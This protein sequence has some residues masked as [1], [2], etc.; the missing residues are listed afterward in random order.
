MHLISLQFYV[1]C[2]IFLCYVQAH[3]DA[4]IFQAKSI[5]HYDQLCTI[6]GN[7]QEILSFSDNDTEIEVNFAVDKGDPDLAIVSEIQTD[8]N[9]TKCRRWT[10]HM[11]HW[12][13]KIL[14][15]Q[16]RKGRKIN[17]VWLTE[18]YDTAVSAINSKFGLHLT[19]S[20]I[21]H[22]LK[23]WKKQYELLKDILS[24]TGFKWDETKKMIVA[25]DST[26]NDYIRVCC[27]L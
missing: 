17:N 3:P 22:R 21:K 27:L 4:R 12:L 24:H 23:T 26:W 5:E 2:L 14:V 25:N 9:Q 15:D 1:D 8:G 20:N 19:K 11:D 18:A 6:F 10:V 13:G 7:D 16:V